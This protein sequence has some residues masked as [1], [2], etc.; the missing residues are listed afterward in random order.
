MQ[1]RPRCASVCN[2]SL[3]SHTSCGASRARVGCAP[4][5]AART[6]TPTQSSGSQLLPTAAA[7]AVLGSRQARCAGGT[8]SCRAPPPPPLELQATALELQVTAL[9][10]RPPLELQ[11][12]EPRQPLELQ[13]LEPRPLLELQAREPQ[14]LALVLRAAVPTA[15]A[16][17]RSA[18]ALQ[19]RRRASG[20]A[21]EWGHSTLR[22]SGAASKRGHMKSDKPRREGGQWVAREGPIQRQPPSLA[23]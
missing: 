3:V 20:G 14:A 2:C 9:E 11:A 8:R 16:P 6:L 1:G 5:K 12:L 17:G 7:A 13:A 4:P 19:R 21:A 15:I 18:A 22:P 10:P 23:V